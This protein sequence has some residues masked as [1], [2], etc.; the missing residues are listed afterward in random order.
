MIIRKQGGALA[1]ER[2]PEE[3]STPDPGANITSA[4]GESGSPQPTKHRPSPIVALLKNLPL[5]DC[6]HHQFTLTGLNLE[7]FL[8]TLQKEGI[9]L[10]S[11]RRVDRRTL[12]CICRSADLDAIA[13]IARDKGWRME[14]S[15]PVGVGARLQRW[16]SRPGLVI[17][18]VLAAVLLAVAMRFVWLIRI[19]DA[20]PYQADIAAYLSEEGIHPGMR[21]EEAN[22]ATLALL[23]QRRYP[24][25]A[26]F[27]VY[28]NNVTLVVECTQ[29]VPSPPLPDGQP[30]DLIAARDGV[31]EEVQVY[32][33]TAVVRP[34]DL[35]RKGQVLIQGQERGAD[36]EMVPAAARGRVLARCWQEETVRV[37]AQETLSRETG[38]G[39][40][41]CQLCT[42]WFCWPEA[43]ESPDYLTYHLYVTDTPVVGSFFPVWQRVAEYREVE[44]ERSERPLQEVKIEAEAAAMAQLRKVLR[45]YALTDTWLETRMGEDGYLYA[46]ASGEYTA[47][48]VLNEEGQ[49]NGVPAAPVQ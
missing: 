22:A 5:P 2:Q 43:L 3:N 7:R 13:A 44:L 49:P 8:N 6:L 15:A 32:G 31:V 33:G 39:E 40:T 36:G 9:A 4:P 26:W 25:V 28:V 14:G 37:S 48:L 27:R 24:Q 42:P 38:R 23:L 18:A 41:R 17:G 45:G 11:A 47:D 16:L 29:G 21:K 46:T 19:V 34:G 1:R 20:G 10:V 35:V 12:R 30:C